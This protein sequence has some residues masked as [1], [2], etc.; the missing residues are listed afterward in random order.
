[1]SED[2]EDTYVEG[3]VLLDGEEALTD[4][5]HGDHPPARALIWKNESEFSIFPQVPAPTTFTDFGK[6]VAQAPAWPKA[7]ET[8]GGDHADSEPE[9]DTA[10]PIPEHVEPPVLSPAQV[11]VDP[12][13]VF[14]YGCPTY[15]P[16]RY[17]ECPYEMRGTVFQ[18][19]PIR[20]HLDFVPRLLQ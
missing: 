12:T 17:Q 5:W 13:K 9:S 4:N 1:V 10:W 8:S 18:A 16:S 3:Y 15:D 7:A 19:S 6:M 20:V 11:P 14:G 2:G